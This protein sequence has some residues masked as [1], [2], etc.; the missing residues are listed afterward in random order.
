VRGLGGA[1]GM[2]WTDEAGD[3]GQQVLKV[4][5]FAQEGGDR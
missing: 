4:E 3:E 1:V 2:R 5:G